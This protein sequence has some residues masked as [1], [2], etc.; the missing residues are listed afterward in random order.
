MFACVTRF[1]LRL[2]PNG[3]PIVVYTVPLSTEQ[4]KTKRTINPGRNPL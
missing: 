2:P 3:L 4:G 1:S